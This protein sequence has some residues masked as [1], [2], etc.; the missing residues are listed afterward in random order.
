MIRQYEPAY[1]FYKR[2]LSNGDITSVSSI[3]T[4]F[5]FQGALDMKQDYEGYQIGI[6]GIV[7]DEPFQDAYEHRNKTIVI[8]E[9]VVK[10]RSGNQPI[11]EKYRK[12]NVVTSG[13]TLLNISFLKNSAQFNLESIAAT[14][15]YIQVD[16]LDGEPSPKIRLTDHIVLGNST[17]NVITSD[18][19]VYKIVRKTFNA[20]ILNVHH[21]QKR[22]DDKIEKHIILRVVLC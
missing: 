1:Y 19:E 8:Q 22:V 15:Q 10:S 4:I 2:E 7:T 21:L 3:D 5:T 17:S 13:Q 11:T 12:R 16:W 14:N 6:I 18:N 20:R 9:N